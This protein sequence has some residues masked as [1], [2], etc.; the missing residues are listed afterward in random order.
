MNIR[1]EQFIGVYENVFSKEYCDSVIQYFEK[2]DAAGFA[3]NRQQQ[4]NVAKSLKDDLAVYPINEVSIGFHSCDSL[5]TVLNDGIWGSCYPEYANQYW[6]LKDLD[7]HKIYSLKV[8]KTEPGQGYHVWHCESAGRETCNKLLAW[9]LYLND[10]KEGGETEFLF[11]HIRVKPKTGTL[12]I[13]P[14][15]FTHI[16]RGNSPLSNTK[17]IVT[18]WIEF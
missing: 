16:H 18:G 9:T 1:H 11:Q 15:G 10:V 4:D 12:L 14:A 8:Q 6:S 5:M 13:W 2:M 17:Y 7:P 3:K